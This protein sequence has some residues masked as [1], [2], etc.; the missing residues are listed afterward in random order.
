[1]RRQPDLAGMRAILALLTLQVSWPAR[2][3]TQPALAHWTLD[4]FSLSPLLVLLVVIALMAFLL[5]YIWGLRDQISRALAN[6]QIDEKMR[7]TALSGYSDWPLGLPRGSVRAV[8]AL[9]IVFGSVALLAVSTVLPQAYKFPD[10]L[11]GI[12]GA[13]LG[14]YFGKN[15]GST[16]GQ[17]VAAVAAAHADARDAIKEATNAKS[18]SREAQAQAAAANQALQDAKG[19]HDALAGDRL[20]QITSGLQ[21]AVTVGQSLAQVLPSKLGESITTAT[22][23]V[24]NSLVAVNDL[25]KGDLS[26]AVQQAGK[27]VEQATPN[28]PVVT[29]LAKAVQAMAPVLGGSIPPVAL[30]TT[31]IGVGSKLGAAAYAHW[32]SRIMDLP[33]TPGQFSPKLFDSNAAISVITQVPT[34]FKAFGPQL[35]AGDRATAVDVVQ[36]ALAA[37]GSEALVN[38]YPQAFAGLAPPSIESAVRDLQ[39]AALDFVLGQEVPPGAAKAVGGLT[40]VL[41]AVDQVRS[42]PEASAALDLVMT[43]AKTLES[44]QMHPELVF[45]NAASLLSSSDTAARSEGAVS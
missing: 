1:M 24:S 5:R 6:G 13:I 12:L 39:K 2:A 14:F 34:L 35:A 19:K 11:V 42:N 3:D 43:T 18:E 38:K 37:E 28:L 7:A 31:L 8:L 36:L 4:L 10:A 26:D 15:G 22:Q 29:V 20:D 17:A 23:V 27:I 44:N 41:K 45:T 9:V 32:I 30:I 25:R 21:D 33:Y 40:S 16:D